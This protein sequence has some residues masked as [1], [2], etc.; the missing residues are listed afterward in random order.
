MTS[1]TNSNQDVIMG[2][3]VTSSNL[4]TKINEPNKVFFGTQMCYLFMRLHHIVYNR[5]TIAR[6]LAISESQ[7]E[8]A[9]H[10]LARIDGPEDADD[11]VYSSSVN[12]MFVFVCWIFSYVTS[13]SF[14][15]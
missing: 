15:D 7:R 13:L 2:G 4:P 14:I 9:S 10:P 6:Q 8:W 1:G 5:L 3:L 12:W 11:E